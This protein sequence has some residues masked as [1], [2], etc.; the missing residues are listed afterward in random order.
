MTDMPAKI[1]AKPVSQVWFTHRVNPQLTAVEYTRSDI[2]E[3]IAE[4]TRQ[5]IDDTKRMRCDTLK[6]VAA[7]AR[8]WAND[9]TKGGLNPETGTLTFF[10]QELEHLAGEHTSRK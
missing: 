5:A 9:N 6:E 2:V 4:V 3:D 10:A 1:W 8:E 7:L